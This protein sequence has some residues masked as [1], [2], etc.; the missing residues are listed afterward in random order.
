MVHNI[1]MSSLCG[2]VVLKLDMAKTYDRV[3]WDYL[4]TILR[5]Y[6]FNESWVDSV[7]RLI[8]NVWYSININGAKHGFFN[9]TRGIK[10]GDPLSPSLFVIGVELLSRMMNNLNQTSFIPY[11]VGTQMDLSL[12]SLLCR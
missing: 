2:N 3:S 10:Q 5:Q 4:C 9:S 11:S 12:T 7:W 1:N 6:G 8:S